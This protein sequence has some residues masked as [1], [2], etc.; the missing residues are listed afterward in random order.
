MELIPSLLSVTED[1]CE[2][3]IIVVVQ[4]SATSSEIHEIEMLGARVIVRFPR[5]SFG[6]A[7]RSGFASLRL[8][9]T[10]VI[11]MDADGSH[12][13]SRIPELMRASDTA[14]VVVA[15][16]YVR[17]GRTD[18]SLLLKIMSRSLNLVFGVVLQI[19]C[20]DISTNFKRYRAVDIRELETTSRDFDIVEEMLFRI[21]VKH[22][23]SFKIVEVADHFK[24]RQFGT[25]KRE[26]GPFII[27]YITTL[28]KLRWRLR[29]LSR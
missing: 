17:G 20:R 2:T 3:E 25:T 26:L 16:R 28:L 29:R 10:F 27:S 6:D 11:T 24:E 21:K 14:D 13:P 19:K 7:L 12:D 5:D 18:N 23:E 15:S 22:G 4:T 9:T 8:D 1:I